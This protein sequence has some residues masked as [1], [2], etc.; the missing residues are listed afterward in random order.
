MVAREVTADGNVHVAS[1]IPAAGVSTSQLYQKL[2]TAGVKNLV[3]PA[4]GGVSAL[5]AACSWAT[6]HDYWDSCPPITWARNNFT[7]PQIYYHD[8]TGAS[9]PVGTV[10]TEWNTSPNIHVVWT[11]GAC[12]A[13]SGTHCVGVY[14]AAYGDLGWLGIFHFATDSGNHFIDGDE[15]ISLNDSYSSNHQ[16]VAC[17]LVGQSI[18]MG[19]NTSTGSCLYSYNPSAGAPNSDDFNEV[20]HVLYPR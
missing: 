16:A 5:V 11:T 19:H 14:E 10:L 8:T 6:A 12:P 2:K 18:G 20:L 1:Y 7:N 15:S 4:G 3:A 13:I 9:W 17:N